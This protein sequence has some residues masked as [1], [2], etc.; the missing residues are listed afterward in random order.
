MS[1]EEAE[2]IA[3]LR[4]GKQEYHHAVGP[5]GESYQDLLKQQLITYN[6]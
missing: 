2:M 4:A 6:S 5:G 1:T 3:D